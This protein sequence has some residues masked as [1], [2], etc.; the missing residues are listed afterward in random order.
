[1]EA[2]PKDWTD[3]RLD[4]FARETY[5]RF[6]EVD[7]RFGDVN[8]RFDEIDRRLIRVEDAVHT[9]G[10]RFDALQESML[11]LHR[12]ISRASV[13]GLF[14]LIAIFATQL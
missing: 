7:R 5:R 6:D 12:L 9:L 13:G 10:K 11:A 1:M 14:A 2:M 4:T 3:D 8:R